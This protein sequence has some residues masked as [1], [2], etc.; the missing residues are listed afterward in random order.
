MYLCL[1]V[2]LDDLGGYVR[3]ISPDMTDAIIGNKLY[4]MKLAG[5]IE[6]FAYDDEKFVWALHDQDPFDYVLK[7]GVVDR[8]DTMRRRML[9]QTALRKKGALPPYV[10]QEANKRRLGLKP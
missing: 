1:A 5:W 9:V 7:P 8:S 3:L 2:T 6:I 10:S 4:S